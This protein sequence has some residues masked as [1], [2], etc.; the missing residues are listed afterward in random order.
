MDSFSHFAE[1]VGVFLSAQILCAM[2]VIVAALFLPIVGKVHTPPSQG[3]F[4]E[5]AK[6]KVSYTEGGQLMKSSC[7][8]C[9]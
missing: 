6:Y 3:S 8:T 5:P 7:E 1:N 4:G 9:I 2:L